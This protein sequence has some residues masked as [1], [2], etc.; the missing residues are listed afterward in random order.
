MWVSKQLLQV[1]NF[2]LYRY[3][4][5]NSLEIWNFRKEKSFCAKALELFIANISN[6]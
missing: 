2:L 3:E 5:K 6:P 4:N 1:V